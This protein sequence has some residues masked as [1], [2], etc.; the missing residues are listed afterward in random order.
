MSAYI[1]A[2]IGY[3]H[4]Q[5]WQA[6]TPLALRLQYHERKNGMHPHPPPVQVYSRNNHLEA[7]QGY[8]NQEIDL[9]F[10]FQCD[11]LR[12]LEVRSGLVPG[13]RL[14]S[15]TSIPLPS[16]SR[17]LGA[18]PDYV[19]Q[20]IGIAIAALVTRIINLEMVSPLHGA[21][22]IPQVAAAGSAVALRII[23]PSA[24][25][26]SSALPSAAAGGV[27]VKG[28]LADASAKPTSSIG[29]S[30]G[31]SADMGYVHQQIYLAVTPL[32]KR[33]AALEV[34]NGVPSSP[35]PPP[36]YRSNHI[37]T[38]G[39]YTNQEIRLAFTPLFARIAILEARPGTGLP[40]AINS[41]GPSSHLEVSPD[42]VN[43][44]IGIA[45]AALNARITA[46]ESVAPMAAVY[47]S[48]PPMAT[49]GARRLLSNSQNSGN[50][51]AA[52]RRL[53]ASSGSS[54]PFNSPAGRPV[55]SPAAASSRA[56]FE[57]AIP[58]FFDR[59]SAELYRSLPKR[60]IPSVP[61]AFLSVAPTAPP[62]LPN[63]APSAPPALPNA[64]PSAE[65]IELGRQ[66]HAA[67]ETKNV[68]E[69]LRLIEAGA[70]LT[71]ENEDGDTALLHACRE[72]LVPVALVILSKPGVDVDARNHYN[73]TALMFASEHGSLELVS[74]LL[75]KGAN[76]H[77]EGY[78]QNTVLEYAIGGRQ[79]DIAL[80]LIERG[81]ITDNDAIEKARAKLGGATRYIPGAAEKMADVL[82]ALKKKYTGGNRKTNKHAVKKR[83]NRKTKRRNSRRRN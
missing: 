33:I 81:A 32:I 30:F 41:G 50:A 62:A 15:A 4:Q 13:A 66:L 47:G 8:V 79:R 74:A 52:L 17:D 1:T 3:V 45:V 10:A 73:E 70:A 23:T 35:A 38:T 53:V 25:P 64:A 80:L 63:A 82:E 44:Q 58:G 43:Q 83:R 36:A 76:I 56:L 19:N 75:D 54:T 67:I 9:A 20:Q 59:P 71:V 42:Y 21:L 57:S 69:S 65:S 39:G 60:G 68:E 31:V 24:G 55:A 28:L 51:S 22:G 26:V 2:N 37:P 72:A 48:A 40:A 16:S 5:I 7:S 27:T 14:P 46:L 11:R 12:A 78:H 49:A 77:A 6:I 29:M 18:T 34:K 61:P